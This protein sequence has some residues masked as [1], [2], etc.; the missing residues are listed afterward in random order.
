MEPENYSYWLRTASRMAFPMRKDW[1]GVGREVARTLRYLGEAI[2]TTAIRLLIFLT[3]PISVPLLALL[4]VHMS[5]KERE[6]RQRAAQNHPF[7]R[8]RIKAA[9]AKGED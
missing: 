8:A 6:Q 2:L 5:K 4:G 7:S 1:S 9:Q 3:F